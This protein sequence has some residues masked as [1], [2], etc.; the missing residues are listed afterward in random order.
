MSLNFKKLL[1]CDELSKGIIIAEKFIKEIC[2]F[3]LIL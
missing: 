2:Q 3:N 1:N